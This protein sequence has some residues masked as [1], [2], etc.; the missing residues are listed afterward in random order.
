MC[1]I[2]THSIKKYL[3]G[4]IYY[5][6]CHL[7]STPLCMFEIRVGTWSS[8]LLSFPVHVYPTGFIQRVPTFGFSPEKPGALLS[9]LGRHTHVPKK[10]TSHPARKLNKMGPEPWPSTLALALCSELW[11]HGLSPGPG[12]APSRGSKGI[13]PCSITMVSFSG[14]Q[15]PL[16]GWQS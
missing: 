15:T 13:I 11:G 1:T 3:N 12:P 8:G 9:E 2:T 4:V 16:T 14:L 10:R 6:P 5:P 7:F